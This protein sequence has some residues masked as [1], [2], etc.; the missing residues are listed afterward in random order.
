MDVSDGLAGDLAKLVGTAG[1]GAVIETD[2]VPLSPA[3]RAALARDPGL[4]DAI[5]TGGDDYEVLCT[6]AEEELALF[7]RSSDRAGVSVSVIGTVTEDPSPPVVRQAGGEQR[8]GVGSF[9]HF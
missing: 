4:L 7:L 1:L 2:S 3:A 8:Y 6:V 9:S 5:L